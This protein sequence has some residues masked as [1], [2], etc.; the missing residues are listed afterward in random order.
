MVKRRIAYVVNHAAFF[1]SHRLPLAMEARRAGFDTCLFTGQ[2]GSDEMENTAV[3]QLLLNGITHVRTRFRSAGMNPVV[4]VV[5]L[6][7]LI[8]HLFRFKPDV[9]HCASPK[10]VLYGGIAARICQVPA[11]VLAISGMG[12]AFTDGV[13]K[14]WLRKAIQSAYR[15][16]AHFAFRH[17]NARVIVQNQDDKAALLASGWVKSD[18]LC[19]IPGSG[20]NL[21]LYASG[22]R[23]PKSRLVLLPA[24]MLKDKG[25]LEFV[26]AARQIRSQTPNWRFV[27]A[28]AA[29]YDNPSSISSADLKHWQ[30]QGLVEWLGHVN[31]MVPLFNEAAIVCLPSYRE[32]MPKALLEA[33]AAGCAVITTDA[34]GC[35]E[36]IDRGV[37]GDLVPVQDSNALAAAL[38]SLIND[39]E[40]R[41]AYGLNGRARAVQLFS[42][43][44]VAQQTVD[45]YKELLRG[46]GG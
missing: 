14:G 5:G 42:I 45:I 41:I 34:T 6:I 9:I 23:T 27:L 24:R 40:R 43:E 2:A 30:G 36:A 21:S 16:L 33:A 32:G 22:A 17:S 38:L 15:A 18:R 29:D 26:D 20:V 11:L 4:E 12:Y 8:W 35:R 3:R 37:T 46:K 44:S 19:L 1:V 39:E 25:I 7:Q 28:G 13:G 10:G 31:D